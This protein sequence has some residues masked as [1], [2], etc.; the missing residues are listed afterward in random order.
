[1]MTIFRLIGLS[2]LLSLPAVAD[3]PPFED[4]LLD[5]FVG[6]WVLSG[7]VAGGTVTHDIAAEWVLGHQYFQFHEVSRETVEGGA[8]AYE[9]IVTI[10]WD[11]PAGQY[12]C[13]W[14]D[15]TGGSGLASGVLG[16]AQPADDQ[17]AFVFGGDDGTFHTTFTYN[18]D[19]DTWD[20]TMDAEKEG[21]RKPFA[22]VTLTR[23]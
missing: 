21:Q 9:S 15:S 19:S 4:A 1:M 3:E 17:L 20:W 22:R 10:G 2:L 18:P 8:L 5:K 11:E 12:V 6:T 16:Y 14:L 23:R 7:T 13:L